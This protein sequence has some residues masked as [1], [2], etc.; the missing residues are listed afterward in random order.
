M[1]F[2]VEKEIFEELPNDRCGV[3]M[4]RG[5]D[6]RQAYPPPDLATEQTRKDHAA[7]H[8]YFLSR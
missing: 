7:I 2:L 6:N 8:G 5:I 3:V 1:K 4:A